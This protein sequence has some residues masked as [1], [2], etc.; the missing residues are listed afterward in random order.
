MTD[1]ELEVTDSF[2][3]IFPD[4]IVTEDW[5]DVLSR[6]GSRSMRVLRLLRKRPGRSALAFA[7]LA[8][9]A[10]TALFVSSPW[11]TSPPGFL[12]R[13]QAALTPP[14]GSILHITWELT[15]TSE[16]YKCTITAGANEIWAD[17]TTPYR[18]RLIDHNSPQSGLLEP[19][20]RREIACSRG[21][22]TE[23]GG[24]IGGE[25]L[26]F[27]PP[28]TLTVDGNGI[29][30]PPERFAAWDRVTALREALADGSAHVEGGTKLDGRIVE[31]IS[32][33]P[34]CPDPPC[35]GLPD[36]WYV[37]PETFL[38]VKFEWPSG[39]HIRPP[40]GPDLHFDIVGRFLTYEYLP[41]TAANIALTDIRAQHPDAT[42]P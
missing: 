8:G 34:S 7:A 33:D 21:T 11:K 15:R 23:I 41:R 19:V 14:E 5:D 13:A 20:D 42:G 18:Y 27:V 16:E 40:E 1:V 36:Y 24:T 3:R 29:V 26:R 6:A 35:S 17:Q 9:A 28:H 32:V 25:S 4:P 37:D 39:F 31:R 10:A 38:P 30:G 12:E 2:E 22:P